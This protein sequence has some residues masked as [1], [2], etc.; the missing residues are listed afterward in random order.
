[1]ERRDDIDAAEVQAAVTETTADA[2]SQ[3]SNSKTVGLGVDIVEIARVEQIIADTPYFMERNFTEEE[4]AYCD[5]KPN[6]HTHYAL[7]FAAKEAVLKA[8]GTGFSNGIGVTDVQ[9]GH[10]RFGKPFVI[11]VGRAAEIAEEQGINEVY[12]SLSYTHTTGVASAV[13]A[14]KEHAPVVE[15][16]VD[17]RKLLT[18]QFKEMRSI[19]N[20]IDAKLA[21]VDDA[22]PMD[23]EVGDR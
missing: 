16:T 21:D 3:A 9:V 12:L 23:E 20:E 6:P 19:L 10:N 5:S 8:L 4:R 1:M 7:H 17:M 11:L 2:A 13:A 22:E 15:E 14:K 18:A